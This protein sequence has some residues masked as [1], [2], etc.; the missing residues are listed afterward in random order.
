MYNQVLTLILFVS[1]LVS[2]NSGHENYINAAD[3]KGV[4]TPAV[5]TPATSNQNPVT[6]IQW[7][8]SVKNIGKISEGEK[9]EIAY[10]FI[11][12][13][14]NPLVISNVVASCGCTV[15][16]KPQEPIAPGKEGIIRASFDSKGKTGTNHKTITVYAN[17]VEATYPLA[18]DVEVMAKK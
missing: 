17:T 9:V 15:A 3:K 8:D 1:F 14:N 6:S 5:A 13:G 10:R 16:E 7:L 18:F 2:C 12:T 11:N 4:V